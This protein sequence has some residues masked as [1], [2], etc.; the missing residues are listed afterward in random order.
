[1]LKAKKKMEKF[2]ENKEMTFL[3]HLEEMRWTILKCIVT[4]VVCVTL[5]LVFFFQFNDALMYPRRVAEEML[6]YEIPI[7]VSNF[8]SPLYIYIYVGFLG[9]LALSLPFIAYFIARFI[10]PGLTSAERK[11]LAPALFSSVIL[12]VAGGAM[13]FFLMLPAGIYF[14]TVLAANMNYE[15]LVDV[16]GYYS[17]VVWM[18][19]SVALAFELPLIEVILLYLGVI[20]ADVLKK[21]RRIVFVIILIVSAI[22]TPTPDA[23]TLLLLTFMLYFMYEGA[24]IIGVILHKRKLKADALREKYE[25]EA[26]AKEREEYVK[27]LAAER[28]AELD[29]E[30]AERTE[31]KTAE[32]A[33]QDPHALPD[34]YDPNDIS[35]D[36]EYNYG[37]EEYGYNEEHELEEL[38][39]ELA[40]PEYDFSPNWDLNKPDTDFFSPHF[41]DNNTDQ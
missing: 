39:A 16:E 38:E 20:K 21:N 25:A 7:R 29:S 3:D 19:L 1:M 10:A 12:F 31:T 2:F 26:D 4:F 41:K 8:M 28:R 24:I 5:V 27:Q 36:E 11:T 17:L 9:G 37:Y 6:G 40:R 35:H 18:T 32:P 23:F 33:A 34:N 13:A 22:I 30:A 15:M 14:M